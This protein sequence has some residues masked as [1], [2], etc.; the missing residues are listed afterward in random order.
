MIKSIM[1]TGANAGLGR[2]CARQLASRDGVDKIYLAC[3]NAERAN[4]AKRSLETVT[5]K[6]IFEVVLMDVSK[7]VSIKQALASFSGSVD[8]LLMNAGGTG[9]K[10]PG[11]KTP[12][13]TTEIFSTNVLGHVVLLNALI[14]SKRLNQVAV[15]VGSE[16]A[17]G[18]PMMGM[19]KPELSSFSADEY[20]S[21]CDGS[22]FKSV[23]ADNGM[24]MYGPVKYIAAMAM[25]SLARRNPGLRIL[26]MSP[27]GTAGTDATRGMP[28]FQALLL[29][30]AV[31]NIMQLLGKMHDL[32]TGAKRLMDAI[33]NESFKSGHFYASKEPGVTGQVVDQGDFAPEFN[34]IE[35]QDSA[36]SGVSRFLD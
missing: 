8:A 22:F 2:E 13:G 17:R 32:E 33:Y 19:K 12:E 14:E 15:Y 21:I 23:D 10:N 25:A 7:P 35:Y 4:E 28:I 18:V 26:T 24:R 27:G 3:R 34:N 16:A 6:Q 1:I 20:A 36:Y 5:G 29:K 11:G 31:M 9:G 30:Y